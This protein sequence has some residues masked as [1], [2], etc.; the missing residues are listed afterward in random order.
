MQSTN[1][2]SLTRHEVTTFT[3]VVTLESGP[4][5]ESTITRSHVTGL[6]MNQ[7]ISEEL[8]YRQHQM[9]ITVL[10]LLHVLQW[11]PN[12]FTLPQCSASQQLIECLASFYF[13]VARNHRANVDKLKEA[14]IFCQCVL[15][16]IP[17]RKLARIR[18]TLERRLSL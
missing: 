2:H 15:Q 4:E 17:T 9:I 6:D 3:P 11:K 10:Q 1:I 13:V 14:T 7:L 5:V 18:K 12:L 8:L 16:R